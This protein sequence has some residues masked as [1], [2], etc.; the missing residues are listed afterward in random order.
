MED[1]CARPGRAVIDD[2]RSCFAAGGRA[3]DRRYGK[4]IFWRPRRNTCPATASDGAAPGLPLQDMESPIPDR[5][6]RDGV[7]ITRARA[8]KATSQ[9]RGERFMA[10]CAQ[11]E[12]PRQ[13]DVVS[14]R[15]GIARAAGSARIGPYRPHL[16]LSTEDL[17][18]RFLITETAKSSWCDLT[19]TPIRFTPTVIIIWRI[20]TN[21]MRGGDAED[22]SPTVA[23]RDGSGGPSAALRHRPWRHCLWL[24]QISTGRFGRRGGFVWRGD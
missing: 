22:G 20:P 12:R 19:S 17:A 8:A 9:L 10:P 11:R 15:D 21:F 2:G 5:N 7:M 14:D 16:D 4:C 1:G 23:S 24:Q 18:E 6:L 13:P 3:R